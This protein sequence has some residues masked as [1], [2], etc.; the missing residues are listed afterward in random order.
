MTKNEALI[1][2][3]HYESD[4]DHPWLTYGGREVQLL[5]EDIFKEFE[6]RDDEL[7]IVY[8]SA[9]ADE[10][11]KQEL[12]KCE[13]CA[14]LDM[15]HSQEPDTPCCTEFFDREGFWITVKLDDYCSR[16]EAS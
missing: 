5:I 1:R 10:R 6:P 16:F 11:K 2:L 7:T 14:Y 8:M 3:T 9:I 15:P 4:I 13:N 12:K